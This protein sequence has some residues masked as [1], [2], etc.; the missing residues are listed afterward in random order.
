M[1]ISVSERAVKGL[2]NAPPNV[3]RAFEK[4][5]RSLAADIRHPSLRAKKFDESRGLWQARIN[6]DWRFYFLIIGDICVI[7]N[8]IPHPK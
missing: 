3:Q 7:T 5:I 8:V 4:Q 1:K 2:A 6:R